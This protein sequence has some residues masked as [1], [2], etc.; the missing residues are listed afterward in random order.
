[1]EDDG[2]DRAMQSVHAAVAARTHGQANLNSNDFHIAEPAGDEQGNAEEYFDSYAPIA[3]GTMQSTNLSQESGSR[4]SA[5]H[6]R[7]MSF[8]QN[9][10]DDMREDDARSTES[11]T[12]ESLLMRQVGTLSEQLEALYTQLEEARRTRDSYKQQADSVKTECI[13]LRSSQRELRAQADRA[14]QRV[15]ELEQ[16]L[17]DYSRQKTLLAELQ[18]ENT[19]LLDKIEDLSERVRTAQDRESNVSN[20]KTEANR[21]LKKVKDLEAELKVCR[22]QLKDSDNQ[23]EFL[24]QARA[25]EDVKYR[26]TTK[27]SEILVKKLTK[28]LGDERKRSDDL[29]TQLAIAQER[30]QTGF[31]ELRDR[32]RENEHAK[33]LVSS[34]RETFTQ[35]IAEIEADAERMRSEKHA[36]SRKIG[37]MQDEIDVAKR[38]LLWVFEQMRDESKQW[39]AMFTPS[40]PVKGSRSS[41][42][43]ATEKRASSKD[44]RD[45]SDVTELVED[46]SEPFIQFVEHARESFVSMLSHMSHSRKLTADER[47]FSAKHESDLRKALEDTNIKFETMQVRYHALEERCWRLEKQLADSGQQLNEY[48]HSQMATLALPSEAHSTSRTSSNSKQ[49]DNSDQEDDHD[50]EGDDTFMTNSPRVARM[51]LRALKEERKMEK[52]VWKQELAQREVLWKGQLEAQRTQHE[53]EKAIFRTQLTDLRSK[54]REVEKDLDNTRKE[55]D[56][57]RSR[58]MSLETEMRSVRA[59]AAEQGIAYEEMRVRTRDFETMENE[60]QVY[61]S[62]VDALQQELRSRARGT[63]APSPAVRKR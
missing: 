57:W 43:S 21:L 55:R 44:Y 31:S 37:S 47:D 14:S 10:D 8:E 12:R 3:Q 54:L 11:N 27:E 17:V 36:L 4:R 18:V 39:M 35:K 19:Q 51:Q 50:V 34:E 5:P 41:S 1:V 49:T 6:S 59:T 48:L 26:K 23:R 22:D 15:V 2:F 29:V 60:M 40:S 42:S 13:S 53:E 24:K 38:Y 20:V 7:S 32:Q 33:S 56:E 45:Q 9:N 58:C 28:E 25:Q 46:P 16:L 30:L 63:A 52:N 61:K 62:Q